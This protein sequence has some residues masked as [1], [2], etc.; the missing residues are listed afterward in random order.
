MK[1]FKQWM[2]V[3]AVFLNGVVLAAACPDKLQ[4]QINSLAE[5]IRQH[6]YLYHVKARP[7]IS[8]AEFD[9]LQRQLEHLRRC[10]GQTTDNILAPPQSTHLQ[11]HAAYMGSLRKAGTSKDIASFIEKMRQL[12]DQVL[13]QPKV[14]GIALEL[15]YLDGHLKAASTRGNGDAGENVLQR[16]Q[17]IP[18]VPAHIEGQSGKLILH[19]ELFLR[20]DKVALS[21]SE[22]PDSYA[23]ARHHA[24]A[25]LMKSRVT[26]KQ[27]ALLDFF[28]WYWVNSVNPTLLDDYRQLKHWGFHW[29]LEYSQIITNSEQAASRR[30][31]YHNDADLPFLLDGVVLKANKRV[32]AKQLPGTRERPG[33][34]LAWKFP[35]QEKVTQVK[36]ISYRIGRSGR[37]AFVLQ[38]EPVLFDGIEVRRVAVGGVKALRDRD[39]APGD[40]ISIGFKGGANPVFL[41]VLWRPPQRKPYAVP[42]FDRYSAFSCMTLLSEDCDQQFLARLFWIVQQLKLSSLGEATLASLVKAGYLKALHDLFEVNWEAVASVNPAISVALTAQWSNQ[43]K[44]AKHQS[45]EKRMLV[46]GIPGIGIRRAEKLATH[47]ADWD[48]L[49]RAS[50]KALVKAGLNQRAAAE[51]R[52]WLSL[53]AAMRLIPYL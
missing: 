23:S 45:F 46:A 4:L 22:E 44:S 33:W 50:V 51:V 27:L 12:D 1:I 29:P 21:A 42:D 34:V 53:P 14:D 5:T 13:I 41:K 37:A 25:L 28:P 6:E 9:A 2:L 11:P 47:F 7:V 38:L 18:A 17:N 3:T 31:L 16:I 49:K 52:D 30:M 20:R 40:H 36:N 8:D 39:V 32:T 26:Q 35:P 24:A 48:E 19:G 15:V 10:L 43:L